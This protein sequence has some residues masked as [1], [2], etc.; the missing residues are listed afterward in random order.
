MS[1]VR[2]IYFEKVVW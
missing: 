1:T 2:I